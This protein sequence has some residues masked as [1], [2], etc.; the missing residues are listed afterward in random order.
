MNRDQ[1]TAAHRRLCN[2][3]QT[4]ASILF[5]VCRRRLHPLFDQLCQQLVCACTAVSTRTSN[6]AELQ[7]CSQSAQPGMQLTQG[8]GD[9][10]LQLWM[11]CCRCPDQGRDVLADVPAPA[12][13]TRADEDLDDSVKRASTSVGHPDTALTEQSR[14]AP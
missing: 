12:H 1:C 10:T 4:A 6:P 14:D 8:L 9:D 5:C 11:L 3:T 2:T 13:Q 7:E